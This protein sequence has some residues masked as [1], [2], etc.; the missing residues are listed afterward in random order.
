MGQAFELTGWA[1]WIALAVPLLL[2]VLAVARGTR[3]RRRT[4]KTPELAT[5][6]SVVAPGPVASDAS[7][8][9]PVLLRQTEAAP[10]APP[11]TPQSAPP[12]AAEKVS[13]S[14]SLVENRPVAAPA[15]PPPEPVIEE[16]VE[17]PAPDPVDVARETAARLAS[18]IK[19]AIG[20]GKETVAVPLYISEAAALVIVGDR[21]AAADRLRK[22]IRLSATLGMK[23]EHALARLELG[24]IARHEGDLT[25]ACEHWSIARSLMHELKIA[26][27]IKEAEGRIRNHGCPT[28]WVLNDF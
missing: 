17:E 18:E 9:A 27:G 24:D 23:P 11:A 6:S 5:A 8:A 22:S 2:L 20:A 12:P 25:T 14:K 3:A 26:D 19:V 10:A 21:V 16:P 13:V 7:A 28:D 15:A 4:P 1:A